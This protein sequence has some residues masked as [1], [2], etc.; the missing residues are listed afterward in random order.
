M[1]GRYTYR[2][3]VRNR[4]RTYREQRKARNLRWLKHYN[5]PN[6]TYPDSSQLK[7]ISTINHIWKH[8]DR[9][10]KLAYKHYGDKN[11]WWLIAWFN[12]APTEGHLTLG[13]TVQVPMPL[14][15]AL[16]YMR[17]R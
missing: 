13:Q 8:G 9:Y 2:R 16:S 4:L 12:M 1:P 15:A 5:S 11:L 14:E 10:Y 17:D 6:M 7:N 3:V